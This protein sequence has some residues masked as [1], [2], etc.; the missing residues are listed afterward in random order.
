[1]YR[2]L[3][4]SVLLIV[5]YL[6]LRQILRTVKQSTIDDRG[7]SVDQ[8]QM[9]LDPMCQTFVPRRIALIRTIGGKTHYFC[10]KECM[11]AFENRGLDSST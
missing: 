8:D 9:V 5:L 1:M 10:S 4:V 7:T 2:I 6:L 11:A 3:L